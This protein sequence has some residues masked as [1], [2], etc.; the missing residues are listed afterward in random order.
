MIFAVLTIVGLGLVRYTI[1]A[2][3]RTP[4]TWLVEP[5]HRTAVQLAL[6]LVPFAG[7]AFL[8]FIGV[9]RNRLGELEDQFF[10]TVFLGSGL[11]FIASACASAA[12]TDA[13]IQSVAAGNIGSETYYFGRYMGDALL[14]LFAMKMAAVFMFSTCTVGLRTAIFPRW[15]AYAGFACALM[16]LL[17]IANWRWITLVFP[18]W[19]L[20]VSSQIFMAE[21]RSP[22]IAAPSARVLVKS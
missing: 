19:M 16:L 14:N 13:V 12:V 15:V 20:L 5:H 17:L 22:G 8:W 2:D 10:A 11:L 9:L 7:I 18:I 6:S 4:G 21:F 1:P 3:V